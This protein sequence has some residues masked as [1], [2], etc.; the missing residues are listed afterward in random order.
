M[1]HKGRIRKVPKAGEKERQP[2]ARTINRVQLERPREPVLIQQAK[3]S[4]EALKPD[5][6]QKLQRT[7]GNQTVGRL[8]VL[9]I[10]Q[11]SH[12]ASSELQRECNAPTAHQRLAAPAN[13]HEYVLVTKGVPVATIYQLR[14]GSNTAEGASLAND[15]YGAHVLRGG[16]HKV[17]RESVLTESV[18][19]VLIVGGQEI[20]AHSMIIERQTGTD[21]FV[22]GFNNQGTFGPDAP[23]L[24]EDQ[25]LRSLHTPAPQIQAVMPSQWT[26]NGDKFKT[27]GGEVEISAIDDAS[28][29]ANAAQA[30]L[31]AHK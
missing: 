7:V 13:C 29:R 25:E 18:G 14:A 15:W 21:T 8:L 3:G 1:A 22:R 16:A 10:T 5:G 4:P 27:I 17:T 2:R 6:V 9:P 11:I 26:E 19:T 23:Y 30:V 12:K 24:E 31:D 20:P 28:F